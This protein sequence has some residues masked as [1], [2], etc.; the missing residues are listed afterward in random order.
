MKF[1][2]S[3]S[4][5]TS[6]TFGTCDGNG[7]YDGVFGILQ[8]QEAEI[9]ITPVPMF[10]IDS[11]Y[12]F[13]VVINRITAEW[14]TNIASYQDPPLSGR[15]RDIVESLLALN[16]I[17]S[18][19]YVLSMFVIVLMLTIYFRRTKKMVRASHTLWDILSVALKQPYSDDNYRTLTAKL[20][21]ITFV[22]GA[23]FVTI[24]Y[25]SMFGTDLTVELRQPPIETL[26]DILTSDKNPA[27]ET[28]SGLH[29][30]GF[31]RASVDSVRGQIWKRTKKR[32]LYGEE[33]MVQMAVFMQRSDRNLALIGPSI[34][35]Q[36]VRHVSCGLNPKLAKGL[37]VS[38]HSFQTWTH[39]I[40]SATNARPEVVRLM[41]RI[42]GRAMET[43]FNT[44]MERYSGYDIAATVVSD[45]TFQIA[46]CLDGQD[47]SVEKPIVLQVVLDNMDILLFR[48]VFGLFVIATIV[49][50]CEKLIRISGRQ[51]HLWLTPVVKRTRPRIVTYGRNVIT[52]QIEIKNVVIW[53]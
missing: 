8:R 26:V 23:L 1:Q 16:L 39:G 27:F 31:K 37:Y 15:D 10:T 2:Y 11:R 13:P 3:V 35:I 14:E 53:K 22:I 6:R 49:L 9:A 52:Q 25:N 17:P 4:Y 50:Y 30:I 38:S 44:N 48:G 40:A 28:S 32:D 51:R 42:S 20:L 5:I 12:P 29:I 41:S 46:R 34:P 47:G 45:V 24:L 43:G 33:G 21:M 18:I 7:T 19:L 36:I